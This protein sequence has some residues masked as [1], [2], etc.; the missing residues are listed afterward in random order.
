MTEFEMSPAMD[1]LAP[2]LVKVQ[3]A[4]GSVEKSSYNPGFKSRY[5]DLAA[6]SA[7]CRDALVAN[8]FAVTQFPG[9]YTGDAMQMTTL[10]LHSSGQFL[11][12][13]MAVPLSKKDAQGYGS[14]L[15]Y[16]R[17]YSL[18]AVVG[19]SPEDDDGNAAAKPEP[20]KPVERI[21]RAQA[22]ELL[23]IGTEVGAN[24]E[25]FCRVYKIEALPELPP[26]KF[27]HAKAGL[28]S[29]RAKAVAA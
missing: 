20:A 7:A 4:T 24:W 8:G 22:D 5:A 23:A 10:L 2:A 28:E 3:E 25:I 21:T 16:A 13:T 6:T 15:T 18:Q 12:G 17:R 9:G 19:L 27:A 26:E 11:R 29:K 1:K 14:A